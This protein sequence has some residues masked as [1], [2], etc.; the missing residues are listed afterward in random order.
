MRV[1]VIKES[2]GLSDNDTPEQFADLVYAV[3]FHCNGG[4]GYN[5]DLYILHGDALGEPLTLIRRDGKLVVA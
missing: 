4:P 3:K 5:G 2:W 1:P